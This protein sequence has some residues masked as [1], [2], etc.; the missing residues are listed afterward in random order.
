MATGP[1]ADPT[2]SRMGSLIERFITNR[3]AVQVKADPPFDTP[4]VQEQNG[5]SDW[6]QPI[7]LQYLAG[8]P[9]RP[10]RSRDQ[11]YA[12][13]QDM[14]GDP[15]I[16]AALRLHVTGALGGHESRGQMIFVEPTEDAK[17]DKAQEKLVMSLA[18][19]LQPLLDRIAPTVCFT[20]VSFGDG[21]GRIYGEPGVGVRDVYTDELVLPP[22]MQPYERANTTV[23]YT[24]ASGKK[25]T[26]R[27]SVLQVA[28]MKMPR[29]MYVPQDRVIEKTWRV[30]LTTDKI[31]DLPA[32]PSIV[33]G[34]FLD[35]AEIAYDKFSAAWAGLVGQRVQDSIDETMVSVQQAGMTPQQRKTL[36]DSLVKMFERSNA[37]I[38]AVVAA[39]KA[40]V[41]KIV[42]FIPTSSDKQ[43]TEIRGPAGSGRTSSLTIDDVMMHARFLAG[44]LGMDLSMIGFADQLG[45]GLGEGGFF[46]V[47][48]QSAE[49]ARSIRSAFT[50]FADH[51]IAVHLLYKHGIDLTG[52]KL[53]WTINYFS[54]ISALE[55]ERARTKLDNLNSAA[56]M[57]QTM[58]QMKGLG[59]DKDAMQHFLETEMGLDAKAAKM[60]AEALN[61]AAEEAKKAEAA[62]NGGGFGG[63]GGPGGFGGPGGEVEEPVAPVEG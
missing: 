33:G 29:T 17:K 13:W 61:K 36:K 59:L 7:S 23:G 34:S 38:R 26:D 10:V 37:N 25:F 1:K 40:M 49:R 43:L 35:G 39:G 12:K 62:A 2:P 42:H 16:S 5:W 22:L 3:G 32:V 30:A 28:R 63:P 52:K 50:D 31:E 11:I 19:D 53:P 41:G 18:E 48:A 58:D 27:L 54:G 4:S 8:S 56:L 57:T 24:V 46:R 60:Y 44:S 21:Y 9:S 45:G 6:D 55:T 14:I 20:A 47:S 51:I 15:V